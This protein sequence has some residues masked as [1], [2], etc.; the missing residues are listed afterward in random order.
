MASIYKN[1][2]TRYSK[3]WRTRTSN[4]SDNMNSINRTVAAVAKARYAEIA[5]GGIEGVYLTKVEGTVGT[6]ERFGE[7]GYAL[8]AIEIDRTVEVV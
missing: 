2:R 6:D 7:S 8:N 5:D 3:L 4:S 1:L